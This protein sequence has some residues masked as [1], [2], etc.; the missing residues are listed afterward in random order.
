MRDLALEGVVRDVAAIGQDAGDFYKVVLA[1]E[2]LR[3]EQ[4]V[5]AERAFGP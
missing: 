3:G 5:V 4:L 2:E 1:R